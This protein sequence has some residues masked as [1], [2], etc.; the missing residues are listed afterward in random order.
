M[1]SPATDAAPRG[2]AE[3]RVALTFA[4]WM[5]GSQA[6]AAAE[7]EAAEATDPAGLVPLLAAI[8]RSLIRRPPST[9]GA[10]TTCCAPIRPSQSG[11]DTAGGFGEN[12]Y[13]AVAYIGG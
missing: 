5:T 2:S 1:L 9:A 13:P 4:A 11:W 3:H 7:I 8:V 6:R 12:G 10:W